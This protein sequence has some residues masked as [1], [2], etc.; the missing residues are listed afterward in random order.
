MA[1]EKTWSPG[2]TITEANQRPVANPSYT[3]EKPKSDAMIFTYI[4][5]FIKVNILF[6]V[7]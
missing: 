4:L 1:Y 7:A 3:T 2:K 6:E 5:L